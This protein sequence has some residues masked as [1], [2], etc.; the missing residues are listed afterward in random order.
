MTVADAIITDYSA[1]SIEAS[2]LDK[3]VYFYLYDL[4]DYLEERGLNFNPLAEMPDCASCDFAALF[5]RIDAEPYDF[6]ALAAFRKR[7]VETCDTKNTERIVS[8]ILN[9]LASQSPCGHFHLKE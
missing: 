7:F 9:H 2:L 8:L 4:S 5:R 6:A 1:I 3:P